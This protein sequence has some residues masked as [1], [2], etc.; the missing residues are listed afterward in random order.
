MHDAAAAAW[1]L[2]LSMQSA[3]LA[4]PDVTGFFGVRS[5]DTLGGP[6]YWVLQPLILRPDRGR[7]AGRRSGEKACASLVRDVRPA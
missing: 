7:R 4:D 2:L 3:Y 6:L 5:L 1:Y